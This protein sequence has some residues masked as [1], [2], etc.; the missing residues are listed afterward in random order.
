MV[1]VESPDCNK[2]VFNIKEANL[3]AETWNTFYT[4]YSLGVIFASL[5]LDYYAIYLIK[6]IP[7]AIV[8]FFF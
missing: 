1:V 3:Q 6:H 8:F 5:A 2:T 7:L 4:N